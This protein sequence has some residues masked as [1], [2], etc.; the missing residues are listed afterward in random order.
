[1]RP[2]VICFD[3]GQRSD[4]WIIFMDDDDTAIRVRGTY[5]TRTNGMAFV[6][7]LDVPRCRRK[8]MCCQP[9]TK[10][11]KCQMDSSDGRD[12]SRRNGTL[13][14]STWGCPMHGQ[15]RA[16]VLGLWRPAR[17]FDETHMW[18]TGC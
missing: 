10:C 14:W 13:G 6:V 3:V 1:M 18:V 9:T 5:S 12:A 11:L 7:H 8:G 4:H 15:H 2:R 16:A 17:V